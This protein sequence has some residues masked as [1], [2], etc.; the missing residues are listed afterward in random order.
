ME[1]INIYD[2][3]WSDLGAKEKSQLI[4]AYSF[5]GAS[6]LLGF[7][8][9]IWL[10][11]IPGSVIAMSTMYGSMA[12]AV[13]GIG[14]YFKSELVEFKTDVKKKL[15]GLDKEIDERVKSDMKSDLISLKKD[16]KPEDK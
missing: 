7:I 4:L 3:K 12:C 15:D 9:F 6:I 10:T 14:M 5:A 8:S 2:K 1:N 16:S 11:Y 13:L